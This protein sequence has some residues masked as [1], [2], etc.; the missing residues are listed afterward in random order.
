VWIPCA[1]L[2][3]LILLQVK[4]CEHVIIDL[5][6]HH[7]FFIQPNL[8]SELQNLVDGETQYNQQMSKLC[9]GDN[10]RPAILG[11]T[12]SRQGGDITPEEISRIVALFRRMH[13]QS[14]ISDGGVATERGGRK[15][16]LHLQGCF[17]LPKMNRNSAEVQSAVSRLYANLLSSWARI[18][19]CNN[20]TLQCTN[21]PMSRT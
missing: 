8:C 14:V 17:W 7:Y 3:V 19:I 9:G 21:L 11:L 16:N 15:G 5:A 18:G 6:Y 2:H 13:E 10:G 20:C 12:I 4:P 1:S